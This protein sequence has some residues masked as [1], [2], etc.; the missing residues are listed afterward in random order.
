MNIRMW[1][2]VVS[3]A[4]LAGCGTQGA[5]LGSD[6]NYVFIVQDALTTPGEPARLSARLEEGDL[7]QGR[8]GW[9]IR[10]HRESG[11]FKASSTDEDG[12]ATVLYTPDAPGRTRFVASVSPMGL[13]NSPPEP[14]SFTVYTRPSDTPIVLCDLDRTVVAT[15]FETVLMGNPKPME[16]S[17]KVLHRMAENHQVVYL[18]HRP[19]YFSRKSRTWLWEN[20]FPRGP[21]LPASVSG[22]LSGSGTYKTKAIRRMQQQF[23]NI[24]VG[25]GD[26]VSDALAYHETGLRSFLIVQPPEGDQ[27]EPYREL[28]EKLSALPEAIEVVT[29]WQQ[30]RRAFFQGKHYPPG[31][32][33]KELQRQASRLNGDKEPTQ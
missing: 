1:T 3:L 31:D 20:D 14:Q 12:S 6:G 2:A 16:D 8:A 22:F 5:L 21:V 9:V 10:F 28:A 7:L 33:I 18:T 11:L 23:T 26:K 19:D 4:F 25:V 30:V 17:A 13:E 27:P 15:G 29:N 24:Q 32:L